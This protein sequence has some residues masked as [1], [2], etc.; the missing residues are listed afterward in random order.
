[1]EHSDVSRVEPLVL[2]H[3]LLERLLVVGEGGE[4]RQQPGVVDV[5]LDEV[6]L[7]RAR[8]RATVA[9]LVAALQDLLKKC[10]GEIL[11]QKKI[12]II[13]FL[14]VDTIKDSFLGKPCGQKPFL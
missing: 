2:W 3:H 5:A 9:Q 7:V 6:E 13:F 12:L 14:T 4:R 11:K 10:Q 8:A 1:M